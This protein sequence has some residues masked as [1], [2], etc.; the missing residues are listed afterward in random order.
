M[1]VGK[2]A[3]DASGSGLIL[4]DSIPAIDAR[5]ERGEAGDRDRALYI[6]DEI[7]GK[8]NRTP[9]GLLFPSLKEETTDVQE[10]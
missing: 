2:D 5:R 9:V 7:M 4:R 1:Q 8:R 6:K 10:G 3:L